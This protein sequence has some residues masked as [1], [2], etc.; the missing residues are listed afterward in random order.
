[1]KVT[2]LSVDSE[3]AGKRLDN[4]LFNH[5][6]GVPK[7]HIYQLIRTGQIRING[8]RP[9]AQNRIEEED[10]I[11]IPP[12]KMTPKTQAPPPKKYITKLEDQILF[13]DND[14]I[15]LNKP[16]DIAVHGGSGQSYGVIEAFRVLRPDA[17]SIDLVHRLDKETSGCLLLSKSAKALKQLHQQFREKTIRKIYHALVHGHWPKQLRKVNK[18]IGQSQTANGERIMR[19][20][21]NGQPALTLYKPLQQFDKFTLIEAQPI[22]GRTHQI[23]VHCTSEGYPIAGDPKYGDY[24]QTQTIQKKKSQPAM[25]ARP[26]NSIQTPNDTKN[27]NDH[28]P[29]PLRNP[30]VFY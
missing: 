16:G 18:R 14:L 23:R 3:N 15:V 22:S 7:S 21:P 19:I 25:S 2:Y 8:K 24:Q 1:M 17:P 26:P 13:E 27:N 10:R 5:L 29:Y 30:L 11:R 20:D 6:K 12:V 4:F 28:S 9:K